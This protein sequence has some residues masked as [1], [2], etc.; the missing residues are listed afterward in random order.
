MVVEATPAMFP[1]RNFNP[2]IFT[3]TRFIKR[4]FFCMKFY[5]LPSEE[6]NLFKIQVADDLLADFQKGSIS[7][8][9][10]WFSEEDTYIRKSAYEATS[11]LY[12]SQPN[13]Q[14]KIL[15]LLETLMGNQQEKVKQTAVNA[16]GEF[17]KKDFKEVI[18][19]FEAGLYDHHHSVKNAVIGSIKKSGKANP[20]DVLIWCDQWLL[21]PDK[22][23]RRQ[24]CHGMELRGRTHPEE[25]LP[26]LKK[27]Q[28]EQ[29][30]TV[31][32]M[33]IHV[34][35]QISYKRNCLEKVLADLETWE[36]DNL[37]EKVLEEILDV[38]HNYE[39]FSFYKKV[40]A[41]LKIQEFVAKKKGRPSGRPMYDN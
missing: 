23:I 22:E 35:G 29:T 19:I 30:T 12:F 7:D 39:K 24:I 25:V 33:L 27:L 2:I 16:A 9:T 15:S 41:S 10:K 31:R 4:V 20:I 38:H 17:A 14:K 5:S 3:E 11:Q 28:F 36:N 26:M 6:R 32:N 37:V 18:K 8:I 34:L 40:E 13:L 1:W 21:H